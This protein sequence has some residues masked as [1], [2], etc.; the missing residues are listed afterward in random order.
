MMRGRQ[1]LSSGRGVTASLPLKK[2]WAQQLNLI[3]PL[4]V[5]V[6]RLKFLCPAPK[7]SQN[8]L[9]SKGHKR[10]AQQHNLIIPLLVPVTSPILLCPPLK[11]PPTQLLSFLCPVREMRSHGRWHSSTISNVEFLGNKVFRAVIGVLHNTL[12]QNLSISP[13][14]FYY[15]RGLVCMEILRGYC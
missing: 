6:P 4:L 5:L 3:I 1:S 8:Q 12:K 7:T 11:K 13:Q 9:L 2:R 14:K 10:W 15:S